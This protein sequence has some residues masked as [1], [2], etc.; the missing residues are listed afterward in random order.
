MQLAGQTV[1]QSPQATH[2]GRPSGCFAIT[3]VPRQRGESFGFSSGY[4][5]VTFFGSIRCLKVS[6]MPRRLALKY[7]VLA[8]GR[9]TVLTVIAM[10]K[11]RPF[12]EIYAAPC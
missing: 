12:L 7:D 10:P 6:A 3:C 8:I 9:R 4:C 1:G 5:S 11:L 2:F